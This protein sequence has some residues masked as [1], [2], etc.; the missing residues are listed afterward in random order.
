MSKSHRVFAGAERAIGI[1]A[2]LVCWCLGA[3]AYAGAEAA[4]SIPWKAPSYTRVARNMDLRTALNSFAV[5]E[6]LSIVISDSVAGEFSGDFRDVPAGEFL[7]KLESEGVPMTVATSTDRYCIE[8]AFEKHIPVVEIA[9]NTVTVKV[10]EVDHP[11]LE[12]HYIQFI[13]LETKQGVQIKKLAPG[14]APCAVF[15]LAEGDAPVA[16]YEYCN[17]HGLWK[18]EA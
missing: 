5:A 14:E 13:V 17:L 6:G 10:G 12:E 4:Q 8:A 9:G 7:D 15:A 18:A 16:A 2:L 11:M 1:A 3:V